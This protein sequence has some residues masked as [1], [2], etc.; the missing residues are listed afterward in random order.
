MH[1]IILAIKPQLLSEALR[2]RLDE[3]AD[4][5][6]VG[7]VHDDLDLLIAV[8]THEANVVIHSWQANEMPEIYTHLMNEFPGLRM[9]GFPV[10]GAT[11]V[12]CEQRI[13][14]TPVKGSRPEALISS[15]RS[16]IT[17]A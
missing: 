12:L 3:E 6:V 4:L 15:I 5:A 2:R 1:R 9:Y 14:I 11:A 13:S 7:H 10:D 17:A 16:A 8:R